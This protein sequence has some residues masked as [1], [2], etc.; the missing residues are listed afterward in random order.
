M[1]QTQNKAG[2]ETNT[3]NHDTVGRRFKISSPQSYHI[4][5]TQ[6]VGQ[7][8][9]IGQVIEVDESK[10]RKKRANLRKL[11]DSAGLLGG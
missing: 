10:F 1:D 2:F 7:I 9:N 6:S 8:G 11:L 4:L 3:Q 5:R